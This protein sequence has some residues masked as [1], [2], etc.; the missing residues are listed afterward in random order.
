MTSPAPSGVSNKA[1]SI[2]LTNNS[3]AN[4]YR[5]IAKVITINTNAWQGVNSAGVNAQWLNETVTAADASPTVGQIQIFAK[6]A[7]AWVYGTFE[8]LDDTDFGTQLPSLLADGK[9]RLEEGAFATGTGVTG[10]QTGSPRGAL[11]AISATGTGSRVLSTMGTATGALIGTAAAADVYNLQAALPPRFRGDPSC[12]WV[13]NLTNI[14][15]IRALDQYGGSSFWA[16]LGPDTPER[17]LGKPIYESS[18]ITNST[19]GSTASGSCPLV[20]GAWSN[21]MIVDRV[22]TSM[23]YEPNIRDTTSNTPIGEAGWF[24]FWRVGSDVTTPAAFRWLSNGSG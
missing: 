16:N 20:F 21:F 14:N 4:P 18:S 24:Y 23:L 11:V 10:V 6:K 9:D 13:A 7:A 2:V 15:K 1:P 12:G 22:G 17:L 8:A 5:R 19:A 3:S